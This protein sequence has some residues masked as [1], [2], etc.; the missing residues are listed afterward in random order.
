[1]TPYFQTELG[2]L[3]NG[4]VLET[5]RQLP[6]ASVDCCITSPPYWNLRDYCTAG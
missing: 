4:D 1:M 6:D 3:Y 5:L 2:K